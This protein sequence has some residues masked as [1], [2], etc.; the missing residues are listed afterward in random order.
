MTKILRKILQFVFLSSR[1]SHEGNF[2]NPFLLLATAV[3]YSRQIKV[4]GAGGGGGGGG[5]GGAKKLSQ[6]KGLAN[7]GGKHYLGCCSSTMEKASL[8]LSPG[9]YN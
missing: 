4:V 1:L 9:S 6:W 7:A 5:G 3:E 2:F 8:P